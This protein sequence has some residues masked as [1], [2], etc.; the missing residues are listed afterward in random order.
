[1]SSPIPIDTRVELYEDYDRVVTDI[2]LFYQFMDD[3]D[4]IIDTYSLPKDFIPTEPGIFTSDSDK[5]FFMVMAQVFN[6]TSNSEVTQ[7]K[8]PTTKQYT[9]NISFNIT[10]LFYYSII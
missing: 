7:N 6:N 10:F 4:I 8:E 2:E 5:A 3:T 9:L 1:M